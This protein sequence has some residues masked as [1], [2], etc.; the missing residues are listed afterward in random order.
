MA[1]HAL[2][3]TDEQVRV[4]LAG[5]KTQH[6]VPF[7]M[8]EERLPKSYPSDTHWDIDLNGEPVFMA[9]WKV[10][11]PEGGG[12]VF[13]IKCP[14]GDA[15][16]ILWVKE[17]IRAEYDIDATYSHAC[18]RYRA[19]MERRFVEFAEY[20]EWDR[21]PRTAPW[22]RPVDMPRWASRLDLTVK[23]VWVERL[24]VDTDEAIAAGASGHW[25]KNGYSF[26]IAFA[27]AP[28]A[29]FRRD[30]DALWAKRGL[31]WDANPWV[32]AC[33]CEWRRKGAGE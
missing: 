32:W 6:R 31:G 30:W 2:G 28:Q 13:P 8:P 27:T 15:G 33:E 19:D 11:E 20:P 4:T 12:V 25:D 3:L 23:R 24:C 5:L 9:C 7:Y 18:L 16:D 29:N 14:F 21:L 26:D 17:S 10:S 22:I 1:E